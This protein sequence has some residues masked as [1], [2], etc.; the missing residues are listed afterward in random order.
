MNHLSVVLGKTPADLQTRYAD[1]QPDWYVALGRI[2]AETA[3]ANYDLL[4]SIPG[5]ELRTA[6]TRSYRPEVIAPHIVGVVGPIPKE[7]VEQWRAQG[8]SGD[9]MVG[10]MGLE[11]WGE[12][13][14]PANGVD[15][16][17]SSPSKVDR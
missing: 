11:R 5:V 3:Q 7:E 15:G 17:R 4:S 8:Y 14:W 2:G 13:I 16:W 12:P 10:R 6:W 1:A 9:E